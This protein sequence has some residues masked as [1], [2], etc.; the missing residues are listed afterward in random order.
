MRNLVIGLGNPGPRYV[1]TRHNVGFLA[2]D[3]YAENKKNIS[4]IKKISG[5]NFEGFA[6][7]SNIF[8]KPLTYMNASGEVL[9][10]VFK[11]FGKIEESLLIIYDDIWLNLGE[12]R[13]R[14]SG[15]DGGHNGLKSIIGILKSTDFPR[16][17]I[18]INN[19][20]EHG[21]GNLA[22]YVLN[23]FT[24]EEWTILDKVL[25]YVTIAIDLILEGRI[26]E[27]MNKFNG[28]II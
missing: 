11:K 8:V 27:A 26:N 6:L 12:I 2:L 17:R 25:D 20:Y 5:R 1:F 28:K 16:I 7:E 9:P 4:N 23:P 18:G 24:Q 19:G 14:K 13:I 15:S 22:N 3:K 21:S 10:Y